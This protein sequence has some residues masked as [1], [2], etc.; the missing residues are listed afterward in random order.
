MLDQSSPDRLSG[1]FAGP[2]GFEFPDMRDR[3][4]VALDGRSGFLLAG[5][6]K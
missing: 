3:Q 1:N 5:V 4:K 6:L 2:E